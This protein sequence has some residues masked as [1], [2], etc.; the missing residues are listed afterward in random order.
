MRKRPCRNWLKPAATINHMLEY[1]IAIFWAAIVITVLR[2]AFMQYRHFEILQ[3]IAP[4]LSYLSKRAE[5]LNTRLQRIPE[6]GSNSPENPGHVPSVAVII[7][8]R[9]EASTIA[10]CLQSLIE[11]DF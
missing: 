8:A 10:R 1:F 5:E 11:Q 4:P 6:Q 7:P 9:N 2:R 3:P